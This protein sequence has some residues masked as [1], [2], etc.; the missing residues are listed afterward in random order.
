MQLPIPHILR[1]CAL[2]V[3]AGDGGAQL[4][5]LYIQTLTL[6][7]SFESLFSAF[8]YLEALMFTAMV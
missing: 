3:L 7:F 8:V 6:F 1:D 5:P 2:V 4:L